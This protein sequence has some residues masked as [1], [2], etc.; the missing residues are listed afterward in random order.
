[1]NT[2]LFMKHLANGGVID[3][4]YTRALQ[5]ELDQTPEDSLAAKLDSMHTRERVDQGR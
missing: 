5:L 3:A 1:M 2:F 4:G